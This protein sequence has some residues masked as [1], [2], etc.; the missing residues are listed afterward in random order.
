MM[1]SAAFALVV[2]GFV[3]L[4]LSM[5]RHYRQVFQRAGPHGKRVWLIPFG[6]LALTAALAIC[7][8]R[9]GWGA[10]MLLWFGI[11]SGAGILVVLLIAYRKTA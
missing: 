1:L 3:S 5:T 10:G 8:A 11:L 2:A 7:V 9:S 4:A 6:W